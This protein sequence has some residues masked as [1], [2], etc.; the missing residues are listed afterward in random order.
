MIKPAA[1]RQFLSVSGLLIAFCLITSSELNAGVRVVVSDRTG[2]SFLYE[3][4]DLLFDGDKGEFKF[5]DA[6]P[7]ATFG[8]YELPVKIVRVAVPQ[9]GGVKVSFRVSQ[10]GVI[11]NAE[12]ARV[13]FIF[14][15]K[16]S[17]WNGKSNSD[18][19]G[20]VF[21]A[22]VVEES[23]I[24]TLRSIRV[25]TIR[26]NPVQYH[27]LSKRLVWFNRFEVDVRFESLPEINYQP[28]PLDGIISEMLLNGE[29]GI[30]WKIV[31][32]HSRGNPYQ[33]APFWLKVV[34]DSTG[35][36]RITGA[37]LAAAGVPLASV[38]PKTLNLWTVGEHEPNSF[39]SES[40]R[41]VPIL[42]TGAEDGRFDLR[43]TVIFYALAP[44]HWVNCCSVWVKNL[45][46]RENVYWLSWGAGDGK[47]MRA[48]LEADSSGVPAITL[49]KDILHQEIDADCPARA[50]LMWIWATMTKSTDAMSTL[51]TTNLNLRYPVQV[52]RVMGRLFNASAQN[53]V[54][55]YFNN[56]PVTTFRFGQSPYPAPYDFVVDTV[57]PAGFRDN[58]L[59]IELS[60]D[61]E[62][63]IYLDYLE[64]GYFRRLSLAQGQ[65]YFFID[66]VGVFRFPIQD[67]N[68]KP[69][70]L[71]ITDPYAP[72]VCDG[73]EIK[74]RVAI[75]SYQVSDKTAFAIAAPSQ[76]LRPR[77]LEF[78]SPGRLWDNA[79]RA[80]YWIITPQE[81]AGPACEL[82]RYRNSWQRGSNSL[83]ARVVTLEELYND[84]CFGLEEP[85]AIKHFLQVKRPAYVLL[86]GDATYD[87]RN[88]LKRPK[89]P[90]VPA[91]EVGYG[92]NPETGDRS[93][94]AMDIWYTDL[95]GE[96]T[97]P[98]LILARLPVWTAQQ[99]R[100]FIEKLKFYER[101]ANGYWTRRWLLVADDEY[102]RY[103]DRPDE[104]RFRHID[105]CEVT[106]TLAG[107]LLD[108][109]KVY[110]TE[111]PF[112][113]AKSK[114]QAN[115]V[116]FHQLN[117]GSLLWVFFGH[118]AAHSLTHEEVLTVARVP[119]IKN[120]N[121]CPFCFFGSCSVG[122]FDDTK[123]ECIAEELVRMNG[124]AIATVAASTATPSGNNLVFARNLLLPLFSNPTRT[125]GEC[126]F[127]AW[128]T[129]RSYH[130]FGEPVTVLRMPNLLNQVPAIEPETLGPGR[131]FTGRMVEGLG[132]GEA[133]WRLFGLQM[134]RLYESPIGASIFYSLPGAELARGSLRAKNGR[135]YCEGIVPCG[136]SLDTIFTG[137]GFYA[138]IPNSG[139]FSAVVR[140][141]SINVALLNQRLVFDTLL[142][143]TGDTI[144]PEVGFYYNGRRL[145]D[146]AIVPGNMEIE[147]LIRDS[148]GIMVAPVTRMAPRFYVNHP[149]NA[150][151]ITD[152]L[153][154]DDGSY[155]SARVRLPLILQGPVDSLFVV[156]SDNF[157]N[158]TL[159]RLI[160]RP[161][162]STVLKIDSVLVYPNPVRRDG[163]FTFL[164]NQPAVVRVRIYT[165]NGTL[166]RD[167]GE[168]SGI[169][170]Y[171]QVFWDGRDRDG[172]L[173]SNGIYLF[174]ISAQGVS[175][176]GKS[177]RVIVRDK[178]IVRR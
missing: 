108:P 173:L 148:S 10:G 141:D 41:P 132:E 125:I 114:P 20:T 22:R 50:G 65:L 83:Q 19:G 59:E 162:L 109:V 151:D 79:I 171:N 164:L 107:N 139:R 98:D 103:P 123:S 51:F 36:Y 71:D 25:I 112:L 6:D 39:Y 111:F 126:F 44:D 176:F 167:L 60:G 26:I 113:G 147:L 152:L 48:V 28:D 70:V 2:C 11:D 18:R 38:D 136:I 137:N 129:D 78:L 166:V 74:D 165:L 73:V 102:L 174:T 97:S 42:V 82:A 34:V 117:L 159:A 77:R 37:E 72:V 80:D 62:K 85:W 31:A 94:L 33:V 170:G 75:F 150:V 13:P 40:L 15:E 143:I 142:T 16:D 115:Y 56:R 57:L 76:F 124:G 106:A 135:F 138:P 5:G 121:R 119:D 154:F 116:L 175:Y 21:P 88:N 130:L 168:V 92:L 68:Q 91:Y 69:V 96:G 172:A 86:V 12:P 61:G 87:Y 55:V 161:N 120:D 9:R 3:P 95:D 131:K 4:G 45:Y 140:D 53:D 24:A 93:A 63:K 89:T 27:S 17:I 134:T 110:L 157:L 14:F 47:R 35:I 66:T 153:K 122:R 99:F 1:L 145:R 43:D 64:I 58:R 105:Q 90:G 32:T 163:V 81:F 177:Q 155:Q 156:V 8:E 160:V 104:L 52:Y 127:A 146:T 133:D 144:G 7:I 118:G 49:G 178:F 84:F 30:K 100:S 29:D 169:Y 67:A 158:K 23:E 54:T 46:T 149:A 128:T 101:E